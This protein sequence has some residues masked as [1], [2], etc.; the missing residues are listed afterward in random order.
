MYKYSQY[1]FLTVWIV[2]IR[3][4]SWST[5]SLN[6]WVFHH[7]HIKFLFYFF[8]FSLGYILPIQNYLFRWG[9]VDCLAKLVIISTISYLS[10]WLICS[11]FFFSFHWI[12][13]PALDYLKFS[14]NLSI[15]IFLHLFSSTISKYFHLRM[16]AY[17]R[18]LHIK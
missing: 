14:Y 16:E 5:Y 17:L 2:V 1:F 18:T 7:S 10:L 13:Y 6:L 12:V 11:T 4:P 3:Y 9:M 15:N 8:T